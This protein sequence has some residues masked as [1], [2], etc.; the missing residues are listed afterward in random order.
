VIEI[1][2]TNLT[3]SGQ[4]EFNFSAGKTNI[5]KTVTEVFT[6]KNRGTADLEVTLSWDEE[7]KQFTIKDKDGKEIIGNK[8]TLPPASSAPANQKEI[9]VS[10]TP[11]T[12]DSHKARL[13]VKSNAVFKKL[14]GDAVSSPTLYVRMTGDSPAEMEPDPSTLDFGDVQLNQTSTK[15]FTIKVRQTSFCD[16]II[17]GMQIAAQANG[18]DPKFFAFGD[19]SLNNTTV[20]MPSD[21]KPITLSKGDELKVAVTFRP[22]EKTVSNGVI[23]INSNDKSIDPDNK[24]IINLRAGTERNDRPIARFQ[25]ICGEESST[26]CNKDDDLAGQFFIGNEKNVKVLVD[27]KNSTDDKNMIKSYKWEIVKQ[28][29]TSLARLGASCVDKPVCNFIVQKTG[30]YEVKL[31]I[32]DDLGQ[33]GS[34]TQ[35]LKVD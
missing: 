23:K 33:E 7:D 31:T 6:I 18:G 13:K 3:P 20:S 35:Q 14:E 27:S 26:A 5:G 24:G 15:T 30:I 11:T 10:Y 22:T 16:V 28:P 32:T 25:F 21:A 19:V 9:T 29:P 8:F 4:K 17:K 34:I 2:G 12:C 1:S